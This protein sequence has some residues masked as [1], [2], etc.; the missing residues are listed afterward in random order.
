MCYAVGSCLVCAVCVVLCFVCA[1][2]DVLCFVYLDLVLYFHSVLVQ[3]VVA[4]ESVN[5]NGA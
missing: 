2:C 3:V 1:L 4:E 5:V